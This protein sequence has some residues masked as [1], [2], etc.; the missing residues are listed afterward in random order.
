[1]NKF[2]LCFVFDESGGYRPVPYSA[3]VEE[4][5][6]RRPE[7]ENRYFLP[8]H[9]YLMEVTHEDYLAYYK[10]ERRQRYIREASARIGIV[11]YNALDSED[12][13]GE[14]ILKDIFTS[15][16]ESVLTDILL[17]KL[18]EALL[19]LDAEAHLIIRLIYFEGQTERQCAEVIGINNVNL[20]RKKKRILEKLKKMIEG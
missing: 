3:L 9:G 17:G 10:S 15:V 4:D 1:M 20:H 5:G 19:S 14:D 7:Y 11:S 2:I 12:M 13:L 8:L 16:E 18:R 6:A